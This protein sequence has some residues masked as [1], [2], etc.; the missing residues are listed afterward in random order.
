MDQRRRDDRARGAA[1]GL[2]G[3]VLDPGRQVGRPGQ[4]DPLAG[5]LVIDDALRAIV[6]V[7]AQ[8]EHL[9]AELDAVGVPDFVGVLALA[10]R[11][12]FVIDGHG[13]AAAVGRGGLAGFDEVEFGVEVEAVAAQPDGARMDDFAPLARGGQ[14]GFRGV[15]PVRRLVPGAVVPSP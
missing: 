10:R 15:A 14:R 4:A 12:F 13:G 2:G 3:G 8:D 5:F 1:A 6:A 7:V 11:A 9:H